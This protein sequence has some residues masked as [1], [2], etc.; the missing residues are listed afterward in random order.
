MK[1]LGFILGLLVFLSIGLYFS[2]NPSS[3]NIPDD[4]VGNYIWIN[5]QKIR[6][7]DSGSGIPLVFIHG[8]G[9]SIYSWRKNLEP[10]SKY[11]RVCAPDLP[12]ICQIESIFEFSFP[13]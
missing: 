9:S 1:K 3:I 2:N 6:Y 13:F 11:H 7:L 4:V 12:G 5:S 8:F 10:I